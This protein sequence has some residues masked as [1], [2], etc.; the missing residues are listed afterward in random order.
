MHG[1]SSAAI[2]KGRNFAVK[3]IA[4]S[5]K[6]ALLSSLNILTI[7]TSYGLQELRDIFRFVSSDVYLTVWG[8]NNKLKY[9][10]HPLWN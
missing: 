3:V 10:W 2:R 4:I 1:R 9:G 6:Q 5:N 8:F 7:L